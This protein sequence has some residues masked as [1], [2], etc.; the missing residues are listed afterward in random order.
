[1]TKVVPALIIR[2]LYIRYIRV[3]DDWLSADG[4]ACLCIQHDCFNASP[5]QKGRSTTIDLHG[6][7]R[8]QACRT[9]DHGEIVGFYEANGL[10]HGF[11]F[12]MTRTGS[13]RL[14]KLE[15]ETVR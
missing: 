15:I 4:S 13:A 1:M 9:N 8:T 5:R 11:L 2:D 10:V 12:R 7:T 6:A 3:I 14:V